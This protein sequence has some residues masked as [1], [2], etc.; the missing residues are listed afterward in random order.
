MLAGDNINFA[1]F[2]DFISENAF[3]DVMSNTIRF[4]FKFCVDWWYFCPTRMKISRKNNVCICYQQAHQRLKRLH[5]AS[6]LAQM[7]A[8]DNIN[9]ATAEALAV[10]SLFRDGISVVIFQ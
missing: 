7:R 8:G 9:W 6:R 3:S 2:G 10:G 4:V 5:I 1:I